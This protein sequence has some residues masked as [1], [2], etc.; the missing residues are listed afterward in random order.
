MINS[1][2]NPKSVVVKA[3]SSGVFAYKK[4]KESEFIERVMSHQLIVTDKAMAGYVETY[5]HIE[6]VY[7]LFDTYKDYHNKKSDI[8]PQ[9]R[10]LNELYST[11][12][13]N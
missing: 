8:K 3:P 9:G 6:E 4:L 12:C 10:I 7:R 2:L 1:Y 13:I 5:Q 11:C